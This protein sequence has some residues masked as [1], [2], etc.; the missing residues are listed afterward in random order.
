MD[1][2]KISGTRPVAGKNPGETISIDELDGC[3]IDALVTA[4]HLTPATTKTVKV[5]NPE[6]Q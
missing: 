1:K 5:T 6:E 2:F 3:N 4:G